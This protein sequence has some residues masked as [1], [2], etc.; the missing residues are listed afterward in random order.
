V[1]CVPIAVLLWQDA[2]R[3]FP[4]VAI[5]LTHAVWLVP[6]RAMPSRE[7]TLAPWQ[8]AV[9]AWY[10]LF[11]AFFLGLAV[12]RARRAPVPVGTPDRPRDRGVA[13]AA[14]GVR[15]RGR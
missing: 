9:S 1:W 4:L 15:V 12:V 2:R 14:R 11:G 7:L 10:V 8:V 13:W 5:F 3:W 6:H